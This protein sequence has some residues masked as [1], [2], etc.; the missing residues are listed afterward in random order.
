MLT[1][2]DERPHESELFDLILSFEAAFAEKATALGASNEDLTA[3]V[4]KF[5]SFE[6]GLSAAFVQFAN[7]ALAIRR[8]SELASLT[9]KGTTMMSIPDLVEIER[10]TKGDG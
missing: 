4:E 9:P 10:R 3:L 6:G 1:D 2:D 8:F 5:R 7:A